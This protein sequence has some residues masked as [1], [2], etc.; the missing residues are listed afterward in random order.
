M[1]AP[2]T[3]RHIHTL[4]VLTLDPRQAH[5]AVEHVAG[6]NQQERVRFL[7]L[8]D[9]HHVVIRALEPLRIAAGALGRF[10][11]TDWAQSCLAAER[12]RINE[13]LELLDPICRALGALGCPVTV[14]KS[15]DHWPDLGR[16][17]DLYTN[18][19]MESVRRMLQDQFG[20]RLQ[21]R[22]LGDCLAGKSTFDI[23]ALGK[24][25]EIHSR[26]LGQAGE[27]RALA[28][29]IAKRRVPKEVNGHTFSVPAPEERV[30]AATLQRMYRHLFFRVCDFV[31]T[32]LLVEE[33]TINYQELRAAADLGGIWHGV[34]TFLTIVSDY[35]RA[36]RRKD[37]GLPPEVVSSAL[38]GAGKLVLRGGFFRFPVALEGTS[39]YA[40]QAVSAVRR[41]DVSA[42]VRLG[43]LPPLVALAAL[44]YKITGSSKRIW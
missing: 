40:L 4:L 37:L 29:R 22:S 44:T 10:E 15:L 28:N 5:A 35:V 41:G 2:E 19:D 32:T 42:T 27:H 24:A 1:I 31:N 43:L 17:L 25:L 8:A 3:V 23:P 16:D 34:A 33:L 30:I 13:A 21:P 11:V 6:L 38:F 26:R 7:K 39:L 18:V 14:F 36:Y 20:A 9:S 12:V